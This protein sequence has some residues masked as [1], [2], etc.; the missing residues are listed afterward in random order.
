MSPLASL[1]G[2][3]GLAAAGVL[4]VYL[5]SA[6][7]YPQFGDGLEFVAAAQSG[8]VPHPTGYPLL[9]LLLSLVP[10]G[11]SAYFLSTLLCSLFAAGAAW[12]A[13]LLAGRLLVPAPDAEPSVI[14]GVLERWLPL[15]TVLLVGLSASLWS[16]ATLVEAYALNA[17]LMA[18]LLYILV[19]RLDQP[20][21]W[22]ALA[23]AALF[24]GLAAS[25]HL[26]SLCLA[27]LL[28]WRLRQ[29]H[30]AGKESPVRLG[31]ALL[32]GVAGLLPYLALPLR[33]AKDPS[34]NWGGADSWQGFWWLVGGGEYGQ[35]QFLQLAPGMPMTGGQF[36]QF[37]LARLVQVLTDLG[38]QWIG[39]A[40]LPGLA[41]A[42]M[43]VAL[44][45]AGALGFLVMLLGVRELWRLSRSGCIALGVAFDLQILFIFTY[46]IPDIGDYFLGLWMS[47]LPF[48][49]LGWAFVLRAAARRLGYAVDP[50][51]A[52]RLVVLMGLVALI[53]LGANWKTAGRAGE[54]L[55]PVWLERLFDDLP[56][57]ALL[58]TSGDADLYSVW[59]GQLVEGKRPDVLVVGSNFLRFDWAAESLPT[60][61]PDEAGRVLRPEALVEP[62]RGPGEFAAY[63]DRTA[64]APN[65]GRVPVV[66]STGDG[67]LLRE[68]ASKYNLAVLEGK[69]LLSSEEITEAQ[70]SGRV[71]LPPATA[72]V[73]ELPSESALHP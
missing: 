7:R 23:V 21:G 40:P 65:I 64:I 15:A 24:Q 66:L 67:A 20:I 57:D 17:L 49:V 22:K 62:L 52:G 34:I 16:A 14:A 60:E 6:A 30:S 58:L 42:A 38:G 43:V 28:L 59:Y 61:T 56:Q 44:F 39:G 25:N 3:T 1:K 4:V 73:L 51:R 36:V 72:Y 55:A 18:G 32:A 41:S 69:L 2:R 35:M 10:A 37:A 53:A 54:V 26:T 48:F 13:G 27:P 11:K 47:A 5:L 71:F 29:A 12:L 31:A 45:S 63:L 70:L 68:L 9:L 46:N 8:G 50:A 19:P 33:A